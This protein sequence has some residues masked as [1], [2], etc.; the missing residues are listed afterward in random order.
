MVPLADLREASLLDHNDLWYRDFYAAPPR[1]NAR[2]LTRSSIGWPAQ[3]SLWSASRPVPEGLAQ[4]N[5]GGTVGIPVT[6]NY[7]R[8]TGG[9]ARQGEAEVWEK[10]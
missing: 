6:K 1:A 3:I 5:P 9:R 7:S 10:T 2:N 4:Q 8:Q